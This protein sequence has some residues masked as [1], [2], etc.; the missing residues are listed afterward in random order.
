MERK[1]D[2]DRKETHRK[3]ESFQ[4]N[5]IIPAIEVEV[6]KLNMGCLD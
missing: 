4:E 6:I 1:N 3:K 2:R 5:L